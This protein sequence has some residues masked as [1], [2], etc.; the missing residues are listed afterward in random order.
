LL[1][2]SAEEIKIFPN[3]FRDVLYIGVPDKDDYTF[4]ELFD[5]AGRKILTSK[6]D[7]TDLSFLSSGYYLI[8][9]K[10]KMGNTIKTRKL[11]KE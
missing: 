3:P 2:N 11:I 8:R 7:V 1:I 9:L 6:E 4:F 10:D 5:S